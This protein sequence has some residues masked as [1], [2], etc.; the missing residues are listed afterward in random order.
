MEGREEYGMGW[1]SEEDWR[2]TESSP[3]SCCHHHSSQRKPNLTGSPEFYGGNKG[4]F[5]WNDLNVPHHILIPKESHATYQANPNLPQC[6][7]SPD[8]PKSVWGHLT[9]GRLRSKNHLR[10]EW[11][12]VQYMHRPQISTE[13]FSPVRLI[14]DS[15]HT[16]PQIINCILLRY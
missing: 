4:V 8:A 15:W 16:E 6:L 3:R 7:T 11:E 2:M 1:A 10:P 9:S 5:G 13:G 14:L 12:S